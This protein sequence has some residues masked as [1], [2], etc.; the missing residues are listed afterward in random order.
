MDL[1]DRLCS[2]S[3][4]MGHVRVGSREPAALSV[5]VTSAGV[6]REVGGLG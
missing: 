5:T 4:A 6:T 1:G 3:E 2:E